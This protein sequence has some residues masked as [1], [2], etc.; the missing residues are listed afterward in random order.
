MKSLSVPRT[1][2]LERVPECLCTDK[3]E[4]LRRQI[5]KKKKCAARKASCAAVCGGVEKE[6]AAGA[7]TGKALKKTIG[8]LAEV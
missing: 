7:T 1:T 4:R 6:A 2:A 5:L 3:R 8:A